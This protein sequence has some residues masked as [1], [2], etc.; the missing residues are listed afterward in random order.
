MDITT[1][2]LGLGEVIEYGWAYFRLNFWKILLIF[3]I[4]Y[5]PIN[6]G[7]SFIPLDEMIEEHGLR[8]LRTYQNIVR[9]TEF[10]IGV[11]A[12]MALAHLL[13]QSILGRPVTWHAALV[14]S[15]SRWPAAIITGIS[16]GLIILGMTFLLIVPGIIWALYYVF[17]TYVVAVRG[18]SGKDALDYSKRLVKGQWWRVFGYMLAIGILNLLVSVVFMAPNFL[19][20][21]FMPDLDGVVVDVV[22]DTVG[23]L[24]SAMFLCMTFV[25]FLNNDYLIHGVRPTEEVDWNVVRESIEGLR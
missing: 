10:F 2:R 23:D 12:T 25:F 21:L 7:L 8:E 16:A 19:I 20:P 18:I 9:L 24:V 1:E 13:E 3:L 4:I 17:W 11:I 14:H 6:I 15:L 5:I 22:F